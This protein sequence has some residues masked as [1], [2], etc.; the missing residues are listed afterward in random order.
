MAA[1]VLENKARERGLNIQVASAGTASYHVGQGPNAMS[2]K[3]WSDA[4]YSYDHVAQQFVSSMFDEFDYILVMD[5]ANRA[6]V[7]KLAA[8][9]IHRDKVH[10]LRSFDP[11]LQHIEVDGSNFRELIVPDPW[12]RPREEFEKVLLMVEKSVDGF[13]NKLG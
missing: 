13:L 9:P 2:H 7:L 5:D 1:A 11:Q 10:Y 8:S 6:N 3:V 12:E 4:G